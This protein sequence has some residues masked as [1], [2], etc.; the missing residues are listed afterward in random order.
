[1]RWAKSPKT[2]YFQ[3]GLAFCVAAVAVAFTTITPLLWIVL[4][5]VAVALFWIGRDR[6]R[7]RSS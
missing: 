7:Q 3:L 4:L 5:W 1:M 2:P 6:S